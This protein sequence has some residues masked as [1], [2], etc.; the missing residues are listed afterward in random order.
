MHCHILPGIDDGAQ[1]FEET[2][3]MLEMAYAEGIRTIVATPHH[4]PD[5]KR[6][7]PDI[8]EILKAYTVTKEYIMKKYPD[9]RLHVGMEIRYTENMTKMD[10]Q[11]LTMNKTRAV[12][13]EFGS[14]D[15]KQTFRRALSRY[16]CQGLHVIVAHAERYDLLTR[17]IDFLESLVNQGVVIQVNAQSLNVGRFSGAKKLIDAWMERNLIH[18]VGTD[19][20]S[21]TWRAP[22]MREAYKKTKRRYGKRKAD[23]LF[24]DN[25]EAILNGR[26]DF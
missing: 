6:G 1:S 14:L 7:M 22:A 15:V 10:S 4:H 18:V 13:L 8:E 16:S 21:T 17:D 2:A 5:P 3:G 25:A 12:M 9:M 23:A 20:H 24:H 19:A 26:W 11:I